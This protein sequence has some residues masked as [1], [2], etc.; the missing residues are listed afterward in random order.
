MAIH[1]D[2]IPS[3]TAGSNEIFNDFFFDA[4]KQS[5]PGYLASVAAIDSISLYDDNS[6]GLPDR[7]ISSWMDN[8]IQVTES[9][10]ITYDADGLLTI[11]ASGGG[12]SETTGRLA[13]DSAGAIVGVYI[14]ENSSAPNITPPTVTAFSLDGAPIIF[15]PQ[16]ISFADKVDYATG[17]YPYSVTTADVNG[18]GNID[19][20]VANLYSYSVSVLTND[21]FGA[22]ADKTDYATGGSPYSV[23]SADVN[24]DGAADLIVSNP[25]SNSVSVLTNDG[26]GAFS[27][28]ADYA[29]GS[30]PYS[31]TTADVN[32]DGYADLIVANLNS[33]T[34]SVLINNGY[35]TFAA[36]ADYA[37]GSGPYSVTT[38][39]VS[40]DGKAD[41]IVANI[42]SNS[43]S[44]L[45]NDGYGAFA[46]KVDYA[47]GS[48][49]YS[50]TSADIN[51]DGHADLIIANYYSNS[52]SVLTNDGYGDFTARVDY[53]TGSNPSSVSTADANGDGKVDLIV[54]NSNSNSV[55]VLKNNGDGTFAAKVDYGTGSYPRSVTTADVNGDGTADLIVS[56]LYSYRV[57]V[58]SNT[59][60]PAVTSFIEMSPVHISSDIILNDPDGDA[61][62]NGG[63]LNVQITANAE[64]ADSLS[65]A[66][67]YPGGSGIW[68]DTDGNRVMAGSTE[69]GTADAPFVSDGEAW[70]FSFNENATNALV[71]DVARAL[72]FSNSSYT[73]GTDDR[74]IT[75]TVTDNT[76][77]SASLVETVTVTA[78]DFAPTLTS[79]SDV[80]GSINEDSG[81]I[82]VTFEDLQLKGDESDIEGPVDAFVVKSV[83]N[84]T[85]RIG[86]DADSATPYDG[87]TNNTIDA[88]H[89]AYWAPAA[90]LNGTLNAFAVAAK[91]SIGQESAPPVQVT[92]S[93][94]PVNDDAPVIFQPQAISF[95]A[96]FD[97][98]TG[99]GP[100]SVTIADVS[101]DGNADL[102]VANRDSYTVSVL[103]N[104]G[105]GTFAAGV[106]YSTGS[107]PYSITAADINGDGAADL[108]VA[109][110]WSNNVSVL[111]NNGYGDFTARVDYETG[112]NPYSVT[113]ADVNGDGMADLIVANYYDHSV[114]VLTN[115][116]YGDFTARADYATGY[117]PSSVTTADVNGDGKADLIVANSN[118]YSISV[119][120][121][122]GDGTFA[123]K[124]DYAAGYGPYS[125]TTADVN[126]DGKTDLIVANNWENSVS[127]FQ[128]NGD[129]TFAGRVDYS[130]GTNPYSIT[131]ADVNG[132]GKADLIV[133]NPNSNNISVLK[134]NG[135]GTFSARV[136]YTTGN[137]PYSVTNA[138]VN[139]DGLADLIVA[140]SGS[141][142][143]SVLSNTAH[144][145]VT[146][147]FNMSPVHISSDIIINDPDGD[148]SWNGG[149]LSVQIT[150]N[151]EAADSLSI[152]TSDPGGSGIWLDNE[153]NR[154]MAGS[155]EIGTADAAFVSD[156]EA[157]TFSF[158]ENATNALVQEVARALIFSSS[159]SYTPGTA[160]RSITFTVTDNTFASATLVETVMVTGVDYG[161][162]PTLTLFT[163]AVASTSED[164]GVEITFANLLAQGNEADTDGTVE[165]FVVK[166]VS[167]GMLRIG[168][169]ADSATPYD[170]WTNNTID[171]SHLAYWTP[172]ANLNGSLDAFAVVAKDNSGL[173]SATP[174]QA[175]VTVSPFD[176]A[177]V[178][179]QPQAISFAEKV[180]YGTGSGTYSVTTADVNGDGNIDLIVANSNGE[181]SNGV[182][183]LTNN[184]D[185]TFAD[186]V[187]YSTGSAS[188][189]V[190][191]VDVNG[192]GHA[193]LIVA[194]YYSDSVSV[195]TNNGDGTFVDRTDYATGGYPRSVTSADINGDG[196]ADLIVANSDSSNVSVLTNDGYGAFADRVDYATGSNPSSV[197]TADVNGDG[198]ADLIVANR[199]DYSVSVLTNNGDGTFADRVDYSTGSGPYSVTSAD[200]NG[201]GKA[202]LIVANSGSSNVSVLTNDGYGAFADRA[203]YDT[204]NNPSSVT[205]AD[206]NGDGKADLIVANS[207]SSNVS[208]LKNKG[209]GTFASSV[210]FATGSGP[211]SVTT[212]D[213]NGDGKADLIVAN[214]NSN[215]VS[216]LRNTAHPA[217][218][219]F[220]EMSP[221][222]ISSDIVIN[223][224]DGDASWDGGSLSVQITANAE[225]ADSLSLAV[226]DPG[227]NGIWLDTDGNTLMAGST[228]IGTADAP[229]VSDG[230]AWSFSF[231]ENATNALVQEVARALIFS[232]SS[233]TPGTADRSITFTVT[234]NTSATATLV[235]T[236]TVTA[237]DFA[238]T[239]TSFSD[240]FSLINE[241]SGEVAVT[242]EDLQVKG[243]EADV[244][245]TVEAFVVKSVSNGTLRIGTDAD[246][247]TPYDGWTNNIIDASHQAYWTPAPNLYGTLNAFAVVARDNIGQES[248][249]PVQAAVTVTPVNDDA[250]VIFQPQAIS[251]AAK[252]DYATGSNP[253]SVTT[254][255][256]NGDG[257]ADLIV[258]NLNS[259]TVSVLI[260]NG[261]GT[262]A[263]RADYA[264]GSGPYSVTTADV[265]GDGKADLIVANIYSN[266]V[267][268]LTNDGYGTFSARADYTTGSYPYSVTS[269]DI[270]G[271]GHADLIVA[272][273]LSNSVSVLT[274]DGYGDFTARAD[275]AT[276][277]NPY[278]VTTA[279]V[280]GDG[281]ADLIVANSNSYT[282]SVLTNNGDGTFAA[283]VDYSAGSGPYSVTTADVN[284]DGKVD[285]IVANNWS[286]SVSVLTNDGYGAFADRADYDTGNNPSSVTTADVNGDGKVDLIV[287][288]SNSNNIS[289]LKNKGDGTFA[290]KIDY[291]A[292]NYPYFVTGADVNGDGKVDL[293]IANTNSNSVSILSNTAH[294]AVTSFIEMSPVHIS[295]DIIINDPDGDA[296]W[297][298]G[299]LSVQ[300][301]A[302]A[303]AADSLS[304][305]TIDP[306]GSGIWLDTDGNRVMAGSTEIGTADA[307]SVSNGDTW[308]FSFNASA[309][310]ALV[311][312]VARALIFSNSSYTPGT[313][314][315]SITFTVTDNTS[316]TA[317]LVETVM[318]TAV[319]F[320]PTLTSFSGTVASTSED[321]GVE[322]TFAELLA[323]GN[324]ADVDGTVEGFVVKSVSNGSLR[325]GADAAS[326]T[327]YNGWTN[328]TI[329]A[330]HQ[331]FWTP[332][333]NL[334]GTLNAFA[335]VA[336]DNIGQESATPV[337]ATVTVTSVNDDAPVIFQPQ[338]I[339]FAA[340]VDY[341]TG[342]YPFSVTTTDV[343]GDGNA[344]LIVANY[345]SNSVSVLK[346]NGDGTFAAKV[347][348][349]TGSYPR[350]V[351]TADVNGDGK[352]DLIVANYSSNSVSVLTNDGYGAFAAK[353]DYATG[354]SPISVTT[355]DVNGDGHADLIVANYYGYSVSVLTNNGSGAFADRAD[356]ATGSNPYS[357]T[358]ADVNGDGKAD[359]IVANPNSYTVSVLTNKGDGTFA[360]KVDY[361]TS[362]YPYSVT[363]ADVN[364]D[365][366]ADLIVVNYYSNSVS[367]LKNNG[368]GTFAARV[369][370]TTGNNPSSV[371]TAD[372][373]GDGK[374]DLI[375]A[376]SNSNNISVLKNKGDGTFAA[377]I[378]YVAGTYPYSVTSADVNGDGKADLIIA[379]TNSNSV[380][381]LSNMAHPAVTSFVE[382]TP[383]HIS[384]DIVIND[385]DGDAS[386]IGGT[387]S[388][389]IT[390]NAEAADSL[391]IATANPGGSGIWLDTAGNRVMAGSTEIGTADAA[392]VSNG[393]AWS[394]SFNANAT[395][396]LVQDVARAL[397][398]S[399]SSYTPGTDDRSITFTVTDTPLATASLV[400]TVTVTPPDL[401]A[402]TLITLNPPDSAVGVAV[403]SDIVLTFSENIQLGSGAIEIHSGSETGP[404]VASRAAGTLSSIATDNILRLN[405]TSDLASNT[406][407]F[408]TLA[409][410]SVND[411]VGNSYAGITSYDFTTVRFT[412]GGYSFPTVK[413]GFLGVGDPLNPDRPG[414][415]WDRYELTGVADGTTVAIYMGDSRVDDYLMIERNGLIIARDDD[416][417]NG[418]RSYDAF[419]IWSY[420]A[421]DV[422]RA[423]TYSAGDSGNYNLYLSVPDTFE[424]INAVPT[425]N[426]FDGAVGS[427]NDVTAVA[428]TLDEL[429]ARGDEADA[430]GTVDAFVVKT[431]TSGTLKIGYNADMATAYNA[432]TNY[433]IDATHIAYW[434]PALG[435]SGTINAFTVVARDNHG[436]E[437]AAPVQTTVNVNAVPTFTGFSGVFGSTTEDTGEVEVT[438][439]ALQ[440]Q[441]DEA[442]IDGTVEAFTVKS[443]N[444]TLRIGADAASATPWDASTNNTIDASHQ[445]YWTPAANAN[446]TLNA[447][448]VVARDNSGGES[449][450]PV[451]VTMEVTLVNDGP[452]LVVG[453]NDSAW[454]ASTFNHQILIGDPDPDT[455]HVIVN[456]GDGTAETIFDT[457]E[458]SL[459]ISHNFDDNGV[460]TVTVTADDQQGQ[461]NSVETG[462]FEVTVHNVAPV[463]L[464][465][466]VDRLNTGSTYT[467]SV[468]A[469]VDPGPDTRTGYSINWGDGTTN[470]FTPDEWTTAAGTFTHTYTANSAAETGRTITVNTTD[471]D[472]TFV[473]GSKYVTVN[474]PA[475]DIYLDNARVAE[476]SEA[477]TA[478]GTLY[479][480]DDEGWWNHEYQLLDDA[481]GRFVLVGNQIKVADGAILDYET[482][483]SYTVRVSS[484]D[485]GGLSFEKDILISLADV[486]PD[487]L[488]SNIETPPGVVDVDAGSS[489]EVSWTITTQGTE[490]SNAS[491]TDR[492]YF[493]DPDTPGLDRWV[494]N[495][496]TSAQLPLSGDLD[497]IQSIQVPLNMQGNFH[498][499]VLTDIY[500]TVSEGTLGESNNTAY[501]SVVFNI[502][503]TNLQVE[504]VTIPA[505]GFAGREIEVQWVVK[506]TGNATAPVRYWYDQVYLSSDTTLDGTDVLLA[507]VQNA[508]Y[509]D[510]GQG[511]SNKAKVTLPAGLEGS[512][513]I[514]VKTDAYGQLPEGA[515]EGDNVTVSS[516]LDI[517]PIPLSELSDL[518][519]VSVAAP[520]QALS[521]QNMPLT[522][523]IDNAGLAAI[524]GNST[525]WVERI[526]MSSDIILDGG[527]RLLSTVWRDL[528]ADKLPEPNGQSHFVTTQKV[529]L[530][531]GVSGEAFYFFV[532]VTPVAPV[533]NVFQSND[534]AYDTTPTLVR[535]TPPPDLE[536]SAI[537]APSSAIAGHDLTFTYR[538][539][540]TGSTTTPNSGWYDSLYLSSDTTL[541]AGDTK[542]SDVW[543]SG[544]LESGGNYN[545]TV[546][547]RLA[548]GLEGSWYLLSSADSRNDVFELD[549]AN[550]IVASDA[551]ITIN[552]IP[553]DLMVA[554]VSAPTAAQ[555]G[556]S[557]RVS[558]TVMNQAAG[559]SSTEQWTDSVILSG[560]AVLGNGDD[561]WLGNFT[562]SGVL[563][564]DQTYSNSALVS[565]PGN[566]SGQYQLFV[567]TDAYNQVYEAGQE[568]NNAR[569]LG[570][571]SDGQPGSGIQIQ[572]QPTADLQVASVT[573][574][575]SVASGEWLTVGYTVV[576]AGLGRTNSDWWVDNVILSKDDVFGNGD[577]LYL[578]RVYHSNRLAPTESYQGSG[579]FRL[580]IDMEGDYHVFVQ[581]DA[582]GWVT[583]LNG[584]NNN[585]NVAPDT[586]TVNL[587]LTPDLAITDLQ[588]ADLGT[589]GQPLQVSWTVHNNG[590]A[591]SGGWRQVL[592]LSRDG[593]LDRNTDIYLGYADSHE[594]L[595]ASTDMA[596]S[597]S[598]RIPDG[599]SGK[600]YVFGIVDSNNAI[601]ERGDE[602]N[603]NA[604]DATAVQITMQTPVDLVAGVI[605]VPE[606]GVPGAQASIDYTVT[607]QSLQA[608]TGQWSDSI[609][610]SSDAVWDVGDVLFSRVGISGGLDADASYTRTA[611]GAIPG[612][613]GGD[614]YVILRSDIF[615]QIPETNEANNL[616]A[617]LDTTRMDVEELLL[618]T[619]DAASFAQGGAV[620]YRVDV[621]AGE[622]LR[623]NF[624]RASADGRTE[625]FVSYNA[626][627]SRSDF[628][629]RYNQADSP[630]QSLVIANS[631]AGTYY[632]MAYNASGA[633]DTYSITAD[634]LQ[635]S[636]TELGT[637]A[638]SNKGEVTVR[639]DGAKLTT[640]TEAILVGPDGAEHEAS[641]VYWKDDT[642]LWATFDLR[643]LA[644]DT[645]DVKIQEGAKSA[646]LTDSF[647]VNNGELGHV[648]YGMQNPSALRAGQVG[649]VRVYY[650]NLGETDV[651]AP[652]LNISGNALLKMPGDS[653]F[654][655]TSLQLLGINTEGPAGILSPGAEGSFQLFFIPDFAGTGTVNIGVSGLLPAKVIDWNTIMDASKP[656]NISEEAWATV[657]ANLIAELGS[658]T[659]DYQNNLS[660]NATYLDQLESRTDDVA[661]LFSLDYHKATDGG[662]LL[663]SNAFSVLGYGQIFVWDIT[664]TRQSDGRVIVTIAGAEEYF[665][666][667]S[668]GSY[669]LVGQGTSTLTETGGAFV[670]HQENGTNIL[671][672]ID[673]NFEEIV[674]RNG[675]TVQA[676]YTNGHLMQVLGD[677]GDSLSFAYNDAGRLI[678]QVDQNGHTVTFTYDIDNQHLT[679]VSSLDGTT[680]YSY[681]AEAGAAQHR[682]SSVT[683]ADGTVQ[684]FNY[685]ASGR[686]IQKYLNDGAEAVTYSYV[687]VNEVVVT[688]ALGDTTNLWLNERGQIAQ[689][690]DALGHVSQMRYDANGN[691]TG[692]VHADGTSTSIGYDTAGNPL[693]VQNAL[694]D[695]V[696]FAYEAQFG[697]LA[698]VTDQRGN[699]IGYGYD[700]Q[701]NLNTITYADSSSESYSYDAEGYLHVAVNRSGES[702][703]Y[704]FDVKGHLTEKI[705]S[706]G[707]TATFAYDGHGNLISAVDA[708]S[709]TTFEYD[710]ADRLV[711]TTD[712]DGRWLSYQYDAAGHRTQMAD[713]TGNVTNYSYNDRGYLASLTDGDGHL[714]A[715]Y[716][717]DAAGHLSRGD[718]GN[719]TYTTYEYDAAGQLTHLVNYQTDDT[720]NSSFDYT[721]DA[722]G[723][724]TSETTLD[725]T[726]SYEYDAIGQLTGATLSDGR[727]IAYSYDAAGNRT[728]VVDDGLT[729]NYTANNLNEYTGVG[730]ATYTY[731]ADGNLTGKTEG[732]FT[733]LYAYD[734]ES[735]LIS[736]TTPTESWSYAYDA[737]G[738]RIAS[739]HDGARTEF[740]LDLTGLVNVAG[741]Y[742]GSGN[743]LAAYTYGFGLESQTLTGGSSYYYDYNAIGSTAGLSGLTGDYVNQYSY[744][745][746]GENLTT[747]ETVANSF[748]Y[749]GQWGITDEG[750]GLDFMRARFYDAGDGRFIQLDP[751]GIN[752]GINLYSYAYN[753][754]V[755]IAD[756]FG[757]KPGDKYPTADAAGRDAIG[758]INSTSISEGREYAGR[759]YRN[760]DG[761]Y[762]Y[763]P[764][765]AGTKDSSIIGSWPD[766]TKNSGMYHT[767][768]ADDPD[769]WNEIFSK[770]DIDIADSENVSSYLGTPSGSFQIYT[771]P[772]SWFE[773]V[774][775]YITNAIIP[776]VRPSDPNDI[777]GPQS[778]GD[779]HWTSSQNALPY[780]I[781]YENQASASAPA[782]E[783]TITQTLDS[784]LNAG[785]FRLGD[786]GW[787]DIYIAVP[788]GTSFYIDR[789][790]LTETKGYLV[791]VTAGIDVAKH[792]AYWSFT[793]IDPTT[794]EIPV[795]PTIGFLP[796]NVVK[797][798]G[799]GFVNYT[800]RANAG[801][802]TGTVID[803]KATIV[804]TTQEPID[805]PAIFN[806]LDISAPE[807]HIET[808]AETTVDSAQFLVRWSGSDVGSAI[809]GYTVYV[810]DDGGAYTPWLENTTLTE[811]SY[812]GQP[813]HTYAFYTAATDNAGN[814][815]GVSAQADLTIEVATA[816]ALTDTVSPEIMAVLLPGDGIYATGQSLD[817]AIQFTETVFVDVAGLSPVIKLTVG[818]TEVDAVY[819]SGSGTDTLIFRHVV[820]GG[821]YDIDGVSL[822]SAIVLN[823]ATLRDTAGNPVVDVTLSAGT[824]GGI[825]VD[826]PPAVQN[827]LADQFAD[828][829]QLFSFQVPEDAFA[830]VDT[831]DSLSYTATLGNGNPLPGWLSFDAATR[832]FNG[833]PL[834]EN[835]GTISVK[836]TATDSSSASA[837]DIFD[838]S[839][840]NVNDAPVM[841]RTSSFAAKV[842]SRVSNKSLSLT[843]GD[844]NGDGN[845]DIIEV[846]YAKNAISVQ[847]KYGITLT[848]FDYPAGSSPGS[849]TSTDVN[850][851]NKAD[852]I[853]ANINNN[854]LSVLINKGN[855]TFKAKVDYATGLSPHA[856]TAADINGDGYA[857]LITANSA[858]N[859]L[860]V[861]TNN[862]D[863]TFVA[864]VDYATGLSPHSVTAA[865]VNNDGKADL[866]AANSAGNTLSVLINSGGGTFADKVDY[867]TGSSPSSVVSTDVNGDGKADLIAANSAGNTI[868]VL[869]NNGDGTFADK[870][871]YATGNAPSSV[872]STDV[873]G[874]GKADLVVA[875]S[876]GNTLSVL[877]N[878]GN[879][880]F[881]AKADYAT[882][883]AP[884]AVMN[885]DINNDGRPDLIVA[886]SNSWSMLANTSP[887]TTTFIAHTPVAVSSG[888]LVF[889]PDGDGEW[890]GGTLHVQITAHAEGPDSLSLP[891]VSQVGSAIWL[892]LVSNTLMA[893]STAIGTADAPAVYNGDTWSFSF[894]ANATNALVQDVAR[895]ISFNNI[896]DTPG[897]ENRAVSFTATDQ[898]GASASLVQTVVIKPVTGSLTPTPDSTIFCH[899]G[900]DT[901]TGGTGNDL[902][903]GGTGND[904]L[905]GGE[906]D[907]ILIGRAG[908]DSL[909]GGFGND[910]FRFT[911]ESDSGITSATMDKIT[912]FTHGE[913]KIDLSGI[914]ANVTLSGIQAFNHLMILAGTDSF[915]AP[916]QLQFDSL[917]GILYGN[918]DSDAAPEFAVQLMGVT[919]LVESD[920]V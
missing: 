492:I 629:Y 68:L 655:G 215:S 304:I 260:N 891:T 270:N 905:D 430:D 548:D 860:S 582:W 385:P 475:S 803:A 507:T 496:T 212:A 503:N 795:D 70:S 837:N 66:T 850:G 353:V 186:K 735:H 25:Y 281:K 62:W 662:A 434:T 159:I 2:G 338:A 143:V 253:Y 805:T 615:N 552:L 160:D 118:S 138:D 200:I 502:L 762:S 660:G 396:V 468:G 431:L 77:A 530:P 300:I 790:D 519:V 637:I 190:T 556:S 527:D 806:T 30:N 572:A 826:N 808:V 848:R 325:I 337:Q 862:G 868:S 678:Q 75:F 786:F 232:N 85:L 916:G 692:I 114:S 343:S 628:D 125:V 64:A 721:Y 745:P 547:V 308:N 29:T 7:Y 882:A 319:E 531:V 561:L 513:H 487:L 417:G 676:T 81:E 1:F 49:P 381:V 9:G 713:Q 623:F 465:T 809:A 27:D 336:K 682:I 386:W 898:I 225:A 230:E 470:N 698:Q 865:D 603:N 341:G 841:S 228:E 446:G 484:T 51:G 323:Q 183:V 367:V 181:G 773:Q 913:D 740:Q 607:N 192:D 50:V 326:A 170:A 401:T 418:E 876:I 537:S 234:D 48:Y 823:G 44:V 889:D 240:V 836:V 291:A 804:F 726:T 749:V 910:I 733:T 724:R 701:G 233:Y 720:I 255:D 869:I 830:D 397:I 634:T 699:A 651:M 844:V 329:D 715:S 428:I 761:T 78:V 817:F 907:D 656:E 347:D 387:L 123:A 670:F 545:T 288:N 529:M 351:T 680:E 372:V 497:R 433:V 751:I 156:G 533:S 108:I 40:G 549:N 832:T 459:N 846:Y 43:V 540:N 521:G 900:N 560:D 652:L 251:F 716:S 207:D 216:V 765:N 296:S 864:K 5:E 104:N 779:E 189:S 694:G 284:G 187:D 313:A 141:N 28:R 441:G 312:E 725:G 890:N 158:N 481:E 457:T 98:S 859:T 791:D 654:G 909:T 501:G 464:M 711:K 551:A 244:D 84:G 895:A 221:V 730:S 349:G 204:G 684:Y 571:S 867:A 283:R 332:A 203:D 35:G 536:A 727:S 746:F 60:H 734:I 677:N 105:D 324:E 224:P 618:G 474:R 542:L 467:L 55:S 363:S 454:E 564:A 124:V 360:A 622:T 153:S 424:G 90:N 425:L 6:D 119:L 208:V 892:D 166:N 870:V 776:I 491:W 196:K 816:A 824:T 821:E 335:V 574:P 650:Q 245:G 679:Q 420:R 330:S 54:A 213:V 789:I 871:D 580:P 538:V 199:D 155:T 600:Y 483:T 273:Y 748:E 811:A 559:Y 565:L 902:M 184:G 610:L 350:S 106:D 101:G 485:P 911:S 309:T 131:T 642:E 369:D 126:G 165:G 214:P 285:L 256:V 293:I 732:G 636:I 139:G 855:G 193:D 627:P 100:Y 741:E 854:K 395:N 613:V 266:S 292:G 322:I 140:N 532:T 252:V 411:M 236:V 295:S 280:N 638:G 697:Q 63:S 18:D 21:G 146:L 466:G 535:L 793:T 152:A 469:V 852:L 171:G 894:N 89:Q 362:S 592:Y 744:L 264:T 147:F 695:T 344:D 56:N 874:D 458:N 904:L 73:P 399:N 863:G 267:S 488:I 591:T 80:F 174:V 14:H 345:Y 689:V 451:P 843:T 506:N 16:A 543:H 912:D 302:N 738:N 584:E 432:A 356:Y 820:A 739:V 277:S 914:D 729:M 620:Y 719:G 413:S 370:Y 419:L 36:R 766:G 815:E 122:N 807:S 449:I 643:G 269:T 93:V 271:D 463:A 410:G 38:A 523:T 714:I 294:P 649:S 504:S 340:K 250:P 839:V 69:I 570:V 524:V 437:S 849:I 321:N 514:L 412:F 117:Y 558:W 476:N 88:S 568:N 456:W 407:Y 297:N 247:A 53:A 810:S 510:I 427:T 899:A 23:I 76:T 794:G 137:Y 317:A 710:A 380:S 666:L 402:P 799:E 829:D 753:D 303:E 669:K 674:D 444:G 673:G 162:I 142:S 439:S 653:A 728:A 403:A 111:V 374:V 473:L 421:G 780:T 150:A 371:T 489:I 647:T 783:V 231:N 769:Y 333:A 631:K 640:H 130:T 45:T 235:E 182:S 840:A 553:A 103:A 3:D 157:W 94:T 409:N 486:G 110:M 357:V 72:I 91:D 664:A 853:V 661:K 691:M 145:A 249:I 180:D 657:K 136:D 763:T 575:L 243:D 604:M 342:S 516:V 539:D 176:D 58:L 178:I 220:I 835:V 460:Y 480:S 361:N 272:N 478:V 906:G 856:V 366:K 597:Q 96:N 707:S 777:V 617:S 368:D 555:A 493:D 113:T 42:Y 757:L 639:I 756:I 845:A 365:G 164:T 447:F 95:A 557:M 282:V 515:G 758:D 554:D 67:S 352:A 134:N 65:L 781:H 663:S 752:G 625:L 842:D 287:A 12:S 626:M 8:G 621:A 197:T 658:T 15:Q 239:L 490:P 168:A 46:A 404:I 440:A 917:T 633:T 394:F 605:T 606:N 665:E 74:S 191:A 768:G 518:A 398:F 471:E 121:N 686:L 722:A 581:T 896:S 792:E 377:K 376:N 903:Y 202:D 594:A 314:D 472:G 872:V 685:D 632:V 206:V 785:S 798:T 261:Y 318:V 115:D 797:G 784:D 887:I 717:Y 609:Y 520:L 499:V 19:L 310:N 648:E 494:G 205:T 667:Q 305:A 120:T 10:T 668:N 705:Y 400:E 406:H 915:T 289:V 461:A 834:N 885:A 771:P 242:F 731:D 598:F 706:D 299:S 226:A 500:N 358:T 169:D 831:G 52:V 861:L 34:V 847:S 498:V 218:T 541:D 873:N 583:E 258:A 391:S 750:N 587:T 102:I 747:T 778:F 759:I 495:F 373:N 227:G 612:L 812:A 573:A 614:Y 22:F 880:T 179:F 82:A 593:I 819:E 644:T 645:Y 550:N 415:Y 144:P 328:N 683:L 97:Y 452:G 577:D 800:V 375:V 818:T 737:L 422:I 429:K 774:W 177:P 563:Q 32:G 133:T 274:N 151:A 393:D 825:L 534:V 315:R 87:W 450:T 700:S 154:V 354:S 782:Q 20:I 566:L 702:V 79:F 426:T 11:T 57:S 675:H 161:F 608:V 229:F 61:S 526:Y 149:S 92:I 883:T 918:N 920:F 723:H 26:S 331:A 222:H 736:V 893:G 462:S 438:Y 99:Y 772:P 265:S 775:N 508:S 298:G 320:A 4:S 630:D 742:D 788:D 576:N 414:C 442:D 257:Y 163:D 31:V 392:S 696:A 671:F 635:F 833:T 278:S 378:D 37:T 567:K 743:L 908:A 443:V 268:V 884:L 827:A 602:G 217:V 109:N 619:P 24:G 528:P 41:L 585:Q 709:S 512:Y 796:T 33:Y 505:S 210:D 525:V 173:E 578:G 522:Y 405:P 479:S 416:S 866:I 39:D 83:S 787:S 445:A 175:S 59:S 307:A 112:R 517:Q 383:V 453:S 390:A 382:M 641:K 116:G 327:P 348:Y 601:Y 359:L 435:S 167:N 129:G 408:V 339:S 195:L 248:A 301:T 814:K 364:G 588:A 886:N 579:S 760:P 389:Q 219:S 569:L 254:A 436:A 599:I 201:D 198:Y 263:A 881:A 590:A 822:G 107:G 448:T 704:T 306:G 801:A 47:T 879:G 770:D 334:Y 672:N 17:S 546:T 544:A 858:S 71:Q 135:D 276:G 589:S 275:Y 316:A 828:E 586:T 712:G 279:D 755:L 482:A 388:V 681:V 172:A 209:D 754:P 223:D 901:L 708:D 346:N 624:D 238:P 718:N 246:S 379:N 188:Y 511:Y 194:N 127:V 595:P 148:A 687:G 562:H 838:I 802:S 857:D 13:Y 211:Y 616:K 659:T 646:L 455:H 690:E 764:P 423:T 688:D 259:Y 132:D 888:I 919:A 311:Q 877:I 286:S 767:H 86:T 851:D 355:T 290:A 703:S 237:V 509:L 878:K 241:D 596:F 875:N 611:T 384:S 897:T 262:F 128:N 813:G 693:S 477:G 185:G